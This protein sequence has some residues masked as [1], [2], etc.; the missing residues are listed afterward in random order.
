MENIPACW[1][2]VQFHIYFGDKDIFF[3][4]ILISMFSYSLNRHLFSDKFSERYIYFSLISD[5]HIVFLK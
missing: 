4:S 5:M 2:N 1:F 3:Y